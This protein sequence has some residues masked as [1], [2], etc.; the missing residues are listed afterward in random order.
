MNHEYSD[1][2]T[3]IDDVVQVLHQHDVPYFV[4][5]SLASSMHG[6]F[7]ATNDIDIVV[8]LQPEGLQGVVRALALQFV[9]DDV[10]A[11]EAFAN[12]VSFNLIHSSA[13]LKVDLFPATGAF[14]REA[15]KRAERVL[16]PGT[17]Q[18]LSIATREDILLAKMRWYRAGGET[19]AVQWRDID[20]LADLN[21]GVFDVAYLRKWSTT[22]DVSD[23]L[24]RLVLM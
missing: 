23:L 7:R 8:E 6:E 12:G 10:A 11:K 16:I 20:R 19:S 5:G 22:L 21:R 17:S 14:E 4:T 3:V 24:N 13:Y 18:P 9:V 2:A 15:I 1:L